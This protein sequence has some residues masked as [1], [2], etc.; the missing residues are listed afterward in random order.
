MRVSFSLQS[1]SAVLQ[2]EAQN[3]KVETLALIIDLVLLKM[4][5]SGNLTQ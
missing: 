2:P 3:E 4:E 5:L 1:S